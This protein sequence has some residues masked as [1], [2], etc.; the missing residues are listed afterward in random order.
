MAEKSS[1]G[2]QPPS[3]AE[4]DQAE[5]VRAG[6]GV[7][8]DA[9]D[10]EVELAEVLAGLRQEQGQV[11]GDVHVWSDRWHGR[12]FELQTTKPAPLSS[13]EAGPE[14]QRFARRTRSVR[15]RESNAKR[16]R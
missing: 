4:P 2:E 7:R 6:G 11:L 1:L 9:H 8:L 5:W 3:Q 14:K 15:V 13:K 16:S 12:V 10:G